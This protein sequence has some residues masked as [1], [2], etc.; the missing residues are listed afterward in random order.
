[1]RQLSPGVLALAFAACIGLVTIAATHEA[2]R[3]QTPPANTGSSAIPAP[4]FGSPPSSEVP[5]LFND[6]HVYSK[7]DRLRD[8]RVLAALVR[9]NT[10]LV[11]LR[12]LFE[13]MG[14]TVTYDPATKSV[15]VMKPGADIKVAVGKPE[16][17]INGESRPLDVPPE[18]YNGIV[19]VPL[20][21]LS[22]G[23]GAYVQWV[24]EKRTV[25]IRYI[26]AVPSAPPTSEAPA[27][28]P[29]A[30]RATPA[31]P[32]R[33]STPAPTASPQP[34]KTKSPYEK[35]IVGD[36]IFSPKIYNNISPGNGQ[37]SYKVNV[38]VEFP[39]FNM[40]WMLE[41]E[42]RQWQYP[43]QANG[44]GVCPSGD[45]SCVTAIGNQGQVYVPAF[46]ARDNDFD[47]RF[48]LKIS[49]PRIYIGIGYLF[50]NSN[51]EGGAFETQQHGVGVGL[52]KLPDL[53]EPFSLYGS[54]YFFPYVA[55]NSLQY[56]GNGVLGV[57]QY[58]ILRY[59]IG[60]T[61]DFGNSPLYLD[62]GFAGDHV[63]AK[64]NAPVGQTHTGPYA[65]LGLHF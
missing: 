15:D 3:A 21:V 62:V 22:E 54:V 6:H 55:T 5:I 31:P 56:L 34:V 32:A 35:F 7:P 40:P 46:S 25:V 61:F 14:G 60:G 4:D 48:G 44:T 11:P 19:V 58:E 43:H 50:R 57:V 51:Y 38:A 52:E 29:P 8:S 18:I 2:A 39:L 33:P 49:D 16:V 30:P 13:Q 24:P 37:G 23:L 9:G 63:T 64:Q 17:I 59:S 45:Q 12:S 65:G 42:Y 41:G 27:T 28:A 53:D 20:R 10:V 26:A 47:G 36:Y 1:L